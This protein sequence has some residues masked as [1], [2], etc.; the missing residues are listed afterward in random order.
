MTLL[1]TPLFQLKLRLK[2]TKGAKAAAWLVSALGRLLS[3][4]VLTCRVVRLRE[5]LFSFRLK[6]CMPLQKP[7]LFDLR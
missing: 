2:E 5:E 7:F 1:Q 4:A 3:S 6:P